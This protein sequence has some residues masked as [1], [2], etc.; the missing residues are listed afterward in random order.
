MDIVN[1]LVTEI[2]VV[3]VIKILFSTPPDSPI[4]KVQVIQ[5]IIFIAFTGFGIS[6]FG[7]FMPIVASS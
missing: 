3:P 1:Q 7:T 4:S 2:I 5:D 6:F